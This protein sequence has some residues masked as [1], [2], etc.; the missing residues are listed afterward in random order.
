LTVNGVVQNA[1][2]PRFSR[3]ALGEPDHGRRPGEDTEAVLA[4]TLALTRSEIER[5]RETGALG[6]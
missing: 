3:T 1:P 6:T 4:E 2:A 5:L